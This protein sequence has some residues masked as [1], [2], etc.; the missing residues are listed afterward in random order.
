MEKSKLFNRLYRMAGIKKPQKGFRGLSVIHS[1]ILDRLEEYE[2]AQ[3]E[4]QL[5]KIKLNE[6]PV[7]R[8]ERTVA[9][10]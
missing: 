10:I 1:N 9:W 8:G 7:K 6:I 5:T 4:K 2:T 3:F